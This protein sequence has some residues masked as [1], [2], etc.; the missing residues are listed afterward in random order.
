MKNRR[1]FMALAAG[2][3]ALP[4]APAP[5]VA[6]DLK[7]AGVVVMHIPPQR[8]AT[9]FFLRAPDARSLE[10]S[11]YTVDGVSK[12]HQ[13]GPKK[14]YPGKVFMDEIWN[15]G[16]MTRQYKVVLRYSLV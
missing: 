6:Q 7:P 15:Q 14:I 16:T 9:S 12:L 3:L 11:E 4:Y 5:V 1:E 2:A 10:I 13:Q 8:K